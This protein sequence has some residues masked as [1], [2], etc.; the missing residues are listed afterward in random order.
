[1]TFFIQASDVSHTMQHWHV[2]RRWNECLFVESMMAYKLGRT[3]IDPIQN[4]YAGEMGF[5][6]FYVIPTAKK[7]ADCGVFG[8]SRYAQYV[9]FLA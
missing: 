8:V 5:F 4:W 7:L 3:K 1:M 6:D 2:Y 9:E